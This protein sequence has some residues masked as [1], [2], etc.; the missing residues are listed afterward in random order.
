[1]KK[2]EFSIPAFIISFILASG[3]ERSLRQAMMMDDNGAMIFFERPIALAFFA[4]GILTIVLR[5]RQLRR[6][7]RERDRGAASAPAPAD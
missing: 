4:I 5:A 7:E 3:A 2:A 1:M 6:Q